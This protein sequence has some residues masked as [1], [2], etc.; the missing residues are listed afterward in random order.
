MGIKGISKPIMAGI[1]KTG[2]NTLNKIPTTKVIKI[3]MGKA[4]TKAPALKIKNN[5]FI[6][7]TPKRK[8]NIKNNISM[9]SPFFIG[10][11]IL[12]RLFQDKI[13]NSNTF[14]KVSHCNQV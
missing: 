5:S 13:N 2:K 11:V 1:R 6:I 12:C 4:I 8:I 10:T 3:L 9:S 7:M 14:N